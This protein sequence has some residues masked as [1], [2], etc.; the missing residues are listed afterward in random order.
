MNVH[1]V[2]LRLASNELDHARDRRFVKV[3]EVHRDLRATVHEQAETF[4]ITKPAR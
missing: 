4:H 3:G 2:S 1:A